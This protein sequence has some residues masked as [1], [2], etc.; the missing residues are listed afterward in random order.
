MSL[1]VCSRLCTSTGATCSQ[2]GVCCGWRHTSCVLLSHL[3][4]RDSHEPAAVR[5]AAGHIGFIGR[6][7]VFIFVSV[8]FFRL[9]SN[10]SVNSSDAT[11]IG[12]GLAQLQ[13]NRGGRACLFILGFLLI[14]Y[15]LFAV[16]FWLLT[17]SLDACTSCAGLDRV[18][19][20]WT[21]SPTA[22]NVGHVFA[23]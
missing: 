4:P 3:C 7:G 10:P 18:P 2:E 11:T 16:C 21:A 15:G 8:L 23:V 14:I 12:N 22:V 5:A 17:H 9:I 20:L 1:H 13:K 19:F 6:A